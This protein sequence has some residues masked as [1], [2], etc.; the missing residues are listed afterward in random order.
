MGTVVFNV[1]F[2][3]RFIQNDM[4]SVANACKPSEKLPYPKVM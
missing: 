4:D 2:H 3:N 1:W